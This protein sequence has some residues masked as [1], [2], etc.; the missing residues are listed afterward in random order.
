VF[1]IRR[2]PNDGGK[3]EVVMKVVMKVVT[4]V[5]SHR[6]A[7]QIEVQGPLKPLP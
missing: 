7:P 1:A 5:A 6:M 3:I 4:K 2:R